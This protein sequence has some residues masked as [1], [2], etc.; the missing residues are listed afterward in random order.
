M[1]DCKIAKTKD[2]KIYKNNYGNVVI[3]SL[4]NIFKPRVYPL[5]TIDLDIMID[6]AAK[7]QVE[8]AENIALKEQLETVRKAIIITIKKICTYL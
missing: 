6:L 7:L 5:N 1:S 8:E 3:E 4:K 2:Y